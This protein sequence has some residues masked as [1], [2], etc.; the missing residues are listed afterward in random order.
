MFDCDAFTGWWA[1]LFAADHAEAWVSGMTGAIGAVL[2]SLVTIFW[3]E[4]FNKRT[5][6]REQK[7]REA[8]GMF[9]VLHRLTAIYSGATKVRDHLSRQF[10]EAEN[11]GVPFKTL[12]VLPINRLSA[13][14]EF[15][16]DDLWVAV[17]VGGDDLINAITAL[18]SRFNNIIEQMQIYSERRQLVLARFTPNYI[19]GNEGRVELTPEQFKQV[20]PG[21]IEADSLLTQVAPMANDLCIDSFRALEEVIRAKRS[22][23]RK[24]FALSTQDPNG[25]E[26]KLERQ[27]PVSAWKFWRKLGPSSKRSGHQL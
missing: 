14:I 9:A 4:G 1:Q 16:T 2:G 15:P 7:E 25:N 5:H 19:N 23:F 26:V 3:T 18:D 12:A 6:I 8:A 11:V 10:K 13:P 22:P 27:V 21:L 17:R 24:G 20:Q